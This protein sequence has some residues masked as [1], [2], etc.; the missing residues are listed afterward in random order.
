[1]GSQWLYTSQ[2][3][4]KFPSI[5]GVPHCL[6]QCLFFLSLCYNKSPFLFIWKMLFKSFSGINPFFHWV[7]SSWNQIW[8]TLH[9]NP[10]RLQMFS[11]ALVVQYFFTWHWNAENLEA[12]NIIGRQ[13]QVKEKIPF[14]AGCLRDIFAKICKCRGSLWWKL[15]SVSPPPTPA[16][17]K[18]C[19]L[20]WGMMFCCQVCA[21]G[22]GSWAGLVLLSPLSRVC[23]GPWSPAQPCS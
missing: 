12:Q 15:P 23:V 20:P 10:G 2:H 8:W 18:P 3:T 13:F 6:Q 9:V 14:H 22:Q 5:S 21:Q 7:S 16:K 11:S 19:F 4:G 17:S 1:M